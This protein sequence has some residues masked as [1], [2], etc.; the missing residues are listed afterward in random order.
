M[1]RSFFDTIISSYLK[2][3]RTRF[4]KTQADPASYQFNLL[5]RLIRENIG[6]EN[7][8]KY[9][10]SQI[11]NY[12]QFVAQ[13]PLKEYNQ[14][15]SDVHRMMM[16]ER[17]V[18]VKGKVTWFSKSSGTSSGR[19]KYLP[20]TDTF[21]RR[22]LVQSS[23]DSVSFIYKKQSNARLFS[24]KSL[25]MG[26]ALEKF[27]LNEET[28]VGDISAIM[29]ARMPR[30]GRPFYTPDFETA[31]MADWEEKI[32][33]IAKKCVKENV[34]MFG[35]VPTWTIVLFNKMLGLTGKLNMLEVWPNA[36]SYMHGGV[37]FGPYRKQ[38]QQFFPSKNF[39]YWEIYNASEGYFGASSTAETNCMNLFYDNE[40]FYEFIDLADYINGY[41]N[42]KTIEQVELSKTYVIVVTT[43]SGLWRY[44]IGDTLEFV[45]IAPYRFKMVGRVNQFI[46]AFGEELMVHNAETALENA[47]Q[48]SGV[49]VANYTVA[50]FY[51]D[52]GG[53]GGHEWFIEFKTPPDSLSQFE[54]LLDEELRKLNS[55]YDAKRFKN[56]AMTNLKIKSLQSG[57]F[58]HWMKKNNKLGGQYK[59]PRLSNDRIILEQLSTI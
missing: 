57:T 22:N 13:V 10:F 32:E 47:S 7:S 24:E 2:K 21:Y 8:E 39:N 9:K 50:P 58:Y 19:S 12:S 35:G 42:P 11:S 43:G 44:V 3:R 37:G 5:R 17:D 36:H 6:C 41:D 18:L 51:L 29:L 55:D 20:I 28:I 25:L 53:V 1:I 26:G 40:V 23:W 46:N 27:E 15:A 56:L 14:L 45:S 38:F 34:V 16:G 49:S 52:T 31:L 54:K 48:K 33:I 30:V 4:E 59:V